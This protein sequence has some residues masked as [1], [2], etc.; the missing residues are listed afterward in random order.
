LGTLAAAYAESGQF[1]EAVKWQQKALDNQEYAK[2]Y[3]EKAKERLQ[4][5]QEKKAYTAARESPQ[6]STASLSGPEAPATRVI[7]SGLLKGWVEFT[8]AE[9][10]FAV[11]L[12]RVPKLVKQSVGGLENFT[13]LIESDDGRIYAVSYFDTPA[14]FVLSLDAV[15]QNYVKA[16][17]GTIVSDKKFA[18]DEE[19]P[20]R[21]VL[22]RYANSANHARFFSVGRR[23]FVLILEGTEEFVNSATANAMLDSFR[24]VNK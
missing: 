23:F 24:R 17:K 22:I 14:K 3:G 13:Y 16:R 1:D 8:S 21:D 19:F 15:I 7:N 5:Y 18:L 6:D 11:S 4:L 20:G 9:G 10:K 12:P 2:R